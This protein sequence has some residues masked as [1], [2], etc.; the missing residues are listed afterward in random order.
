MKKSTSGRGKKSKPLQFLKKAETDPKLSARVN[1]AIERGG[2]V[3]AEE[4]I[5][6]ANEFGFS[7]T[8][9]E[10]ERAVARNIGERFQGGEQDVAAAATRKPKPTPKPKPPLESTC[11]RQC[12]SWSINYCPRVTE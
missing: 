3:M 5:Q 4:V 2:K 9:K 11:A 10:F 1:K 8:Q 12:L 6:I 7:F